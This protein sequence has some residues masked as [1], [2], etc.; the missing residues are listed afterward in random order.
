M[1]YA[2]ADD[3][4]VVGTG[5]DVVASLLATHRGSASLANDGEVG[6]LVAALPSPRVG[7]AVVD[8][9]PMFAA[10]RQQFGS[11]YDNL[12]GVTTTG[13]VAEALS[14]QADRVVVTS[15][16]LAPDGAPV[17]LAEPLAERIPGDALAY[18]T[19]PKVGTT[20]GATVEAMLAV[21]GANSG[22][23]MPAADL[24]AA[25]EDAAG[26]PLA[27]L[28]NWANDGAAYVSWGSAGHA[29]GFVLLTDDPAAARSQLEHLTDALVRLAHDSGTQVV[30]EKHT[31]DGEEV[32]TIAFPGGSDGAPRL[33]YAVTDDAA[34]I[35]VGDAAAPDRL[36]AVDGSGSLASSS[37]FMT[38]VGSVGGGG[39]APTTYIDL[40]GILAAVAAQIP[41]D[42]RS[43][44]DTFIRPNLAPL[45]HVAAGSHVEAG[46]LVQRMEL[47]LR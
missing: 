36:M 6:R 15:A 44:F 12:P 46:V 5:S 27:D 28:L 43:G 29:G 35:T 14:L 20:L 41:A 26:F 42:E 45:D 22:M 31:G 3:A 11:V 13:H 21:L 25:F 37:R 39:T 7:L 38:A 34:F 23:G 32:T 40:A 33:A 30:V 47:V 16:S 4:I 9:E 24:A 1:A 18:V 19:L 10:M 8:L 2:V 17:T